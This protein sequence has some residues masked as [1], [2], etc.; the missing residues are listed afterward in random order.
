MGSL[1]LIEVAVAVITALVSLMVIATIGVK[2]LRALRAS[3][4]KS[5]YRRI[6]PALE[7]Y[8]L[9]GLDQ[10]E[11]ERL[12][13]WQQDLFLSSLMVE[14]LA[15]LR[16]A[17]R[18]CL[19]RLAENLG[20]VDRA[21]SQLG[22][23]RRWHRARAAEKLGYFGGARAAKPL[24]EL[25]AAEDDETVRAVTARSLARIGTPEA[26]RILAG[27]LGD[28][29]ELTRLRVAENLD[30]IGHPAVGPLVDSLATP[31]LETGQPHGAV[32]AIRVL[33]N[34]RASEAREV[35]R[36]VA[37]NAGGLDL[38]AQAILALGR[39]GDPDDV[40]T[41][42]EAAEDGSWPVRAQAANALGMIGE[43]S[44]IPRLRELMSDGEWWVRMNSSKALVNMGPA[45]E[46]ALIE[47][48]RGGDPYAR[49]R[50][51]ATLENRGIVRRW[52][53]QLSAEGRWGNRARTAVSALV[54]AG[55]T[56]HLHDL[57][58]TLPEDE[59]HIL[60]GMLAKEQETAK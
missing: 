1:G 34:L 14:R 16:G 17:G 50:A 58:E 54:E 60:C 52:T 51:A 39:V 46:E 6:E 18:D 7:Q 27:T 11:L 29:S 10:P 13:S 22:S 21:L 20:L 35:L 44:T 9:T 15:L 43:V 55:T 5:H 37:L 2:A 53:R 56:R 3:W 38:R 45:G 41:L 26:V 23:R 4:L 24:G 25:L 36:E 8:I 28:P 47:V 49:D 48:L 30:R 42:L 19:M 57:A 33:G 59:R 32:L 40:P 31:D 12:P